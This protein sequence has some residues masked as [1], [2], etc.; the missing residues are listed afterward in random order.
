LNSNL[1]QG[2]SGENPLA[3]FGKT[4]VTAKFNSP[5]NQVSFYLAPEKGA[6]T[7]DFQDLS[8]E[9]KGG[10][11]SSLGSLI[12]DL[13]SANDQETLSRF[14]GKLY[15]VADQGISFRN[16]HINVG[17]GVSKEQILDFVRSPIEDQ[18]DAFEQPT[19][20]SEISLDDAPPSPGLTP[21]K[22]RQWQPPIGETRPEPETEST[23]T[24]IA[25]SG[26]LE[27]TRQEPQT[28]TEPTPE[29]PEPF[30]ADKIT[31]LK[32]EEKTED[33]SDIL[34]QP[35][36]QLA[37]EVN[38]EGQKPTETIP[39]NEDALKKAQM[40]VQKDGEEW[41][42]LERL[43]FHLARA[44]NQK[45]TTI[46]GMANVGD[47]RA[48][49]ETKKQKLA[50]LLRGRWLNGTEGPLTPEQ[51]R[52][53][54]DTIFEELVQKENEAYLAVL[55][56]NRSENWKDKGKEALRTVAGLK[57]V[58]W[59]LK[60]NKWTKAAINTGL[61][62]VAVGVGTFVGGG[63]ALTAMGTVGLRGA[64]AA[65]SI[66]GSGAGLSLDK[67]RKQIGEVDAEEKQAIELIKNDPNL[68]L[69][70]KTKKYTEAKEKYDKERKWITK[71]K[72]MF[73]V[74]GGVVGG[75]VTGGL[76]N[77]YYGGTGGSASAL[78]NKKGGG[79]E[80]HRMPRG[81]FR[82]GEN[83]TKTGET[84]DQTIKAPSNEEIAAAKTEIQKQVVEEASKPAEATSPEIKT[85]VSEAK[86]EVSA[87]PEQPKVAE[88]TEVS[89][90]SFKPEDLVHEVKAGDSTWNILKNTLNSQEQFAKLT[91]A[92]KTYVL[93]ALTN[94][95]LENPADY[96]LG[97]GGSISVGDK[98]DFSKLFSD[99]KEIESI[100]GKAKKV[101]EEGSDQEK[102][103]LA[104]NEKI[105]DW[106]KEHPRTALD[107]EKVAEILSDRPKVFEMPKRVLE[108]QELPIGP[109]LVKPN[110]SGTEGLDTLKPISPDLPV[111][112]PPAPE[113]IPDSGRVK[114]RLAQN[115]VSGSNVEAQAT[116][117][118]VAAKRKLG[119][120]EDG[121]ERLRTMSSDTSAVAKNAEINQAVDLAFK[122]EINDIYGESSL[123]GLKKV[124]GIDTKEWKTIAGLPA[125][126]VLEYF[127]SPETS[128]LPQTILAELQTS[129][130]HRRL[131]EHIAE[132]VEEAHKHSNADFK[133]YD[134]GEN[135]S[136]YIK[137]IG[138]FL[139][140]EQSRPDIKQVA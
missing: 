27:E 19:P 30:D 81:T 92:Q 74:G 136:D 99:T 6:T 139:M 131:V 52:L 79:V 94:K 23:P 123:L 53:Y 86:P 9:I 24:P 127:K 125:R 17:P 77:M 49:Y 112:K 46:G 31:P 132:L 32:E 14:K 29:Q 134:N 35:Q 41:K 97:S 111:E 7:E 82:P 56:E 59:Y 36:V 73:M 22:V 2:N 78:E 130:K 120:L 80:P 42:E 39:E 40:E 50:D 110:V 67:G 4:E 100:I 58:S 45:P 96:Q 21:D 133:P 122:N 34:S 25:P 63:A 88:V 89:K 121:R 55:K 128:D 83:A 13:K 84:I 115:D 15:L 62:G 135:V 18:T 108:D 116:E 101:I 107:Q 90:M 20:A 137:R 93:S 66:L 140:R 57:A 126:R 95:I 113:M 60:Q 106:V 48:E 44:E 37:P 102:S 61:F 87:V 117:E 70:E 85:G 5:V 47:L 12:D 98:T 43:R 26:E 1:N 51:Q 8:P 10:V 33:V 69:E 38:Q 65:G 16:G 64:R 105:T 104:N 114:M 129:E 3:A 119:I 76:L 109:E 11:Y 28:A 124:A 138:G 54:N 103:I 75:S 71:R 72:A 91:E 68:S 118:V